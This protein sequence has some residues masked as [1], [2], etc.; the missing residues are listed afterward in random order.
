MYEYLC[1]E[2]TKRVQENNDFEQ[3]LLQH[4]FNKVNP[5]Q[6]S[7][8]YKSNVGN[9]ILAK[10]KTMKLNQK[11]KAINA[12]DV[13]D[14]FVVPTIMIDKMSKCNPA[15]NMHSKHNNS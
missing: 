8:N 7:K 1:Y 3:M 4:K 12:S 14:P 5:E 2:A 15:H 10:L 11:S 6:M 9:N 13:H